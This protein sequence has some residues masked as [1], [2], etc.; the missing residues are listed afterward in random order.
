[1]MR[2]KTWKTISIISPGN[3]MGLT[4]NS[5]SVEGGRRFGLMEVEYSNQDKELPSSQNGAKPILI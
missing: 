4:V 1:M 3:W 5:I 2:M